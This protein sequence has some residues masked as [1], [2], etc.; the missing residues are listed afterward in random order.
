MKIGIITIATGKYSIYVPGLVSS[1]ELLFLKNH[2]KKYFVYTDSD[3]EDFKNFEGSEKITKIHQ[4]K[5]GWP[6]DSMMRFHMFHKNRD[7]LS[8]MD[9]LFFMNANMLVS[10]EV[11]DSILPINN[12]CGIVSTIHP[13]YYKARSNYPYE[14][15]PRSEF[16]IPENTGSYYF[17]GCFN[18]GKTEDFLDMSKVLVDK[19]DLDLSKGIIPVWHDESAINWYLVNKDPHV[20]P[21]TYAYPEGCDGETIVKRLL[22]KND[23][24]DLGMLSSDII[25]ARTPGHQYEYMIS[26]ISEPKIIQR[27][28]NM[29][30]GKIYLR[31]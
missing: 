25:E 7:I 12:L 3:A 30:G 24:A 26:E 5:L 23:P 14:T 9:Y 22:E 6:Y 29:D 28:K 4:D 31:K 8:E 13:G 20:L 21:P 17:Q 19:M 15:N 11:D 1:C 18:G 10:S 2:E 27:N 16:Y